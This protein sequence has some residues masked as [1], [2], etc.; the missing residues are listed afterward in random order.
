MVSNRFGVF[1]DYEKEI[2]ETSRGADITDISGGPDLRLAGAGDRS[3]A[4]DG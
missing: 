2:E 4:T 1:L 3:T